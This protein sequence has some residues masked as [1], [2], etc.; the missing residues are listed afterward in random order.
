MSYNFVLMRQMMNCRI[1]IKQSQGDLI[2]HVYYWGKNVEMGGE[3]KR[4]QSSTHVI[5]I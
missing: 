5:V 3:I 1:D 2:L 4:K